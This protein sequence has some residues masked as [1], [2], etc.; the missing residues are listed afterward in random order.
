[1]GERGVGFGFGGEAQ[2]QQKS[3]EVKTTIVIVFTVI[4]SYY[5]YV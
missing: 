3:R 4:A 1:M 2:Y 5:I